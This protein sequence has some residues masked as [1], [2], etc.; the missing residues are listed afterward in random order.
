M[1]RT[2][3][4]SPGIVACVLDFQPSLLDLTGDE[5]GPDH[6]D[7]VAF[8]GLVGEV[9]RTQLSRGAWVDVRPRWL[10]GADDLF[11][12]LVS[13]VDCRPSAGRCTTAWSTCRG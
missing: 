8:G 1:T 9:R 6:V 2:C 4:R 3:V 7:E 10:R 5:T 11:A 12:R 13:D